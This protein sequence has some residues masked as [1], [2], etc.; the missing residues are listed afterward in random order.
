[1]LTELN[2]IEAR[3]LGSLVEKSLTTRE[4]Y[5]L[6]FN[7]LLNACNQKTSREPVMELDTD[8][9]G[10][11]VQSLM[12]KGLIDRLQAP[13]DRVPKFRHNI[14][15]LLNSADPKLIGAI[16]VLLLRG[17]Q[18]PGEIKGRTDRL[19]EFNGTAEVEGLLQE[20]CARAEDPFVARL[21]RQSG[22]KEA[23]Y[24]HLFSGAVPAAQAGMPA[25]ASAGVDRL[26]GL[27]KR[28]EA[29]EVMVRAHEE[30][31]A[32]PGQDKPV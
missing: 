19:C 23:R 17:P 16:T 26:A 6:T 12:E 20:L 31:L 10:K 14:D 5:P 3:V 1:M 11:A 27:E 18:T 15:R 30:R 4:Q 25:A 28:L 7:S 21:P 8:A 32:V 29:L 9:M 22:Q 13:G 24:Q 2:I